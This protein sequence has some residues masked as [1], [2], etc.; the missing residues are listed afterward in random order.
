MALNLEYDNT[1]SADSLSFADANVVYTGNNRPTIHARKW[2]NE[3]TTGERTDLRGCGKRC[4]LKALLLLRS[5]AGLVMSN[6]EVDVLD[7]QYWA[8]I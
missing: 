3:N 6:L 4:V 8:V 2:T 5:D 1:K 7:E